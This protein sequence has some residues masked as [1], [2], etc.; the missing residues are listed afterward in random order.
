MLHDNSTQRNLIDLDVADI[1]NTLDDFEQE[2]YSAVNDDEI[3]FI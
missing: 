3:A 1:Y 2:L